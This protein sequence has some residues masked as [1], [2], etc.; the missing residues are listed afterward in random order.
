MITLRPA[1]ERGHANHGWL[2]SWHS[3]SFADYYDPGHVHWGP[4]RVIN[5]DRVA[6]G[7]GFGTHGHR[8]MEIISYV[9]DGAL[10]H[11]DSMGNK[12]S[13]V[14]G[15]VQRMSAGTGVQHSEFNHS[16]TGTTHFLQIWI[17]PDKLGV[18][19]SYDQKTFGDEEKRGRLRMVVSPDGAE[20]SVAIQQDARMYA[21]LFDGDERAEL[22]LGNGRLAYVH[23]IRGHVDVNGRRVSAGDALMMQAEPQ[24]S[25]ANGVEAE[26]LVFDLPE[27]GWE[28]VH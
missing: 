22:A 8:D 9:L 4:L 15:E 10:G 25:I 24:V 18:A 14:P 3:F 11:Q 17:I 12:A 27:Q 26:V 20:G 28:P 7:R 13:I 21:G 6:A 16:E 5:E 1:H 19:P 2:D 23:V